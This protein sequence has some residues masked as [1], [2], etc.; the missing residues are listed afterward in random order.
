MHICMTYKHNKLCYL[1]LT[2]SLQGAAPKRVL[3]LCG[4][5]AL[6]SIITIS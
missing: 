1:V 4:L 6:S 3:R 2:A 5:A